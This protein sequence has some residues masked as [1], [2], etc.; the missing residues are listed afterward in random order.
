[1]QFTHPMTRSE[2]TDSELGVGDS[3]CDSI[4]MIESA[5]LRRVSKTPLQLRT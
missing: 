2:G 5:Y 3:E 4:R 1:M